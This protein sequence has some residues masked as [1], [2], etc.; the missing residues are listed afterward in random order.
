MTHERSRY[1]YPSLNHASKLIWSP[2]CDQCTRKVVQFLLF[3]QRSCLSLLRSLFFFTSLGE[4]SSP[5]GDSITTGRDFIISSGKGTTS[6]GP[7]SLGPSSCSHLIT[8]A[9]QT[10]PGV[11]DLVTYQSLSPS[12]SSHSRV[13]TSRRRPRCLQMQTSLLANS[14]LPHINQL[15]IDD[16]LGSKFST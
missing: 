13:C 7:T 1:S 11:R 2:D 10:R 6:L 9:G 5:P 12:I 16:S 3:S 14:D 15:A 4:E 8:T